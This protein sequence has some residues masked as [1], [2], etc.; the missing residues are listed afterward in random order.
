MKI[1]KD[2]VVNF[3]KLIASIL[4]NLFYLLRD[5]YLYFREIFLEYFNDTPVRKVYKWGIYIFTATLFMIFAIQMNFLWLFGKSPSIKKLDE[6][7]VD[8]ASLLYSSD[9]VLLG[10]YYMENRIPVEYNKI[11]PLLINTLIATEDSRFYEHS[12][13]DLK[14]LFSIFYYAAKG[15]NRG[16]STITQQ[17]AKNL[18]K[19]RGESSKGILGF[20]P[21][22]GTFINKM[23]EWITAVRLEKSY[24]KEEIVTL[25]L[26][27]VD[28]GCNSFGIKT[29]SKT[30]FDVSPDSLKPEQCAVMVGLLKA[31]TT[32]N[33][34]SN[35]NNAK[36]RRNV[37][38][39]QMVKGNLITQHQADSLSQLPIELKFNVEKNY[40]GAGTYFRNIMNN[41][42]KKWCTEHNYDL[43]KDG[44]KIYTTIDTRFQKLAEE[45]VDEHMRALQKRFDQ[46]WKG[47]NPWIDADKKEILTFIDDAAKRTERY[48][49]L[50]KRYGKGHDSI[51]IVMNKPYR[52]KVF[53]WI[54]EQD[55]TF[56]PMDS[57]RYYKRFLHAGFLVVDPFKG[58][59]KA[60]VGGINYK[61]FKYD[62]VAQSSRQPGSTFKPFVYL[63]A[64]KQ[65]YSPCDKIV[66]KPVRIEYLE[67]GEKKVWEPKNSDRVFTNSEMTL[68]RAMAKSV[69]SVTAQL[70]Q[71]V[72]W[73]NVAQ[74]AKELGIKSPLK[75]VP[76]IGLG[77]SDVNLYE[78]VGAYSTF[79]NQ[80]VYTQPMFI[81]RIE[82][83]NGNVIHEFVPTT[84][85]V[86]DPEVAWLMIHM[87]KGGLEEPGGTSQALFE[88]DLFRGNEFG[89]KTGTSNN[90]S[91]GWFMGLSKDLVAGSWVGGED[92]CI[93]FRTSA[94]GEGARTALPI[95]GRF[96]TKVYEHK[97]LGIK[98]GYFP[99]AK[100]HVKR[101]YRCPTVLSRKP[102]S[103]A[104]A[105]PAQEDTPP[106]E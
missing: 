89:G 46:H 74:T 72:G 16:G 99:P 54:G 19:I 47:E 39:G 42:L 50:E 86:L 29:A 60:W 79:L 48:R 22:L 90:H 18:Y 15:D 17:L 51:R 32:Y 68:R 21:G 94:L 43:Y 7:K 58:H 66:D 81:T 9:G 35:P 24:T 36:T 28:F 77:S 34:K 101:P 75:K 97:E 2:K 45:A 100:V 14:A 67:D 65:G 5:Y 40:D 44:L 26:N 85:E 25:Y 37:V 3:I 71:K 83:H 61:Y 59:I 88:F 27:T 38:F 4:I 49:N 30:Y 20:V 95:Y 76:S 69:N 41:Y 91:D 96:M 10:K 103:T 13:I 82:D 8:Q 55:T 31:T 73:E 78:M 56:S 57:I 105:E 11:S 12:G 6:I 104:S 63:T 52:M 64:L 106:A 1:L 53:S 92:R 93:H 23:K 80:G 62:H 84:R 70:T 102:D 87:L 98:M 33:P